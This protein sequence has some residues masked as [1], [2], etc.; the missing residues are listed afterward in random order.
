[1]NHPTHGHCPTHGQQ[2]DNAWGCPE[3]VRELRQETE[4]L[5][6]ELATAKRKAKALRA[7]LALLY[8]EPPR[9]GGAPLMAAA[10]VGSEADAFSTHP[11]A[12]QP[13]QQPTT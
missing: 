8:G 12:L 13:P 9:P 7:E 3:C 11:Q 10:V 4:Q 5:R 6:A 2:P 1:M